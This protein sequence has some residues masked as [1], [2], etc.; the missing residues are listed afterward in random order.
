M[1]QRN[2]FDTKELKRKLE[3]QLALIPKQMGLIAL[4]HFD[5]SFQNQGFTD[6]TLQP[7]RKTKSGKRNTFGKSGRHAG[8]LIGTGRLRRGTRRAAVTNKMVRI[9]NNTEYAAAHNDG[10]KGSVSVSAHTR[11]VKSFTY[12]IK[13]RKRSTKPRGKTEMSIGEHTRNM[14]MPRRRFMGK[15]R[16]LNAEIRKMIYKQIN[17]I[18]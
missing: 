8:I 11:E 12:N 9:V 10:F 18:R 5:K 16:A 4:E 13:T 3:K 14:K 2:K 15:S 17:S 6:T 7:W 1:K